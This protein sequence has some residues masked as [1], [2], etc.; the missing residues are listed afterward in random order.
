M[1]HQLTLAI[2]LHHS[3]LA[4]YTKKATAAVKR[5]GVLPKEKPSFRSLFSLPPTCY[6][7]PPPLSNSRFTALYVMDQ[8]IICE[9]LEYFEVFLVVKNIDI[10]LVMDFTLFEF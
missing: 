9:P 10:V 5:L 2:G 8:V 6:R 3:F 4:I 1:Q 7:G